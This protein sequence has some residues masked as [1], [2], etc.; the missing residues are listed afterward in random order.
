[1]KTILFLILSLLLITNCQKRLFCKGRT[2]IC[3]AD[4]NPVCAFFCDTKNPNDCTHQTYPN[5]CS[6]CSGEVLPSHVVEGECQPDVTYCKDINLTVIK[7]AAYAYVCGYTKIKN[8]ITS[9]TYNNL[10]EACSNSSVD[11]IIEGQC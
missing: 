8:Q 4:Y 7:C 9:Q 11:Y 1:M 3:T 6:S 2:E 5:F 10:C